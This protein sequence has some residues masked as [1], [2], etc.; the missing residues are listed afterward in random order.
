MTDGPSKTRLEERLERAGRDSL[1]SSPRT[2]SLRELLFGQVELPLELGRY[3]LH[4]YLGG[5]SVGRVYEAHDEVKDQRVALK[6]FRESGPQIE[7]LLKREFRS[8]IDLSHPN[9]VTLFEACVE[10]ELCYFT[11]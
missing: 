5:G 10:S 7:L 9:L 11:M 1:L 6:I 8:L 4:R 3:T 2:D